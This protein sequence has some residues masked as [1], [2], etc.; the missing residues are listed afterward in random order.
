MRRNADILWSQ[1]G[2]CGTGRCAVPVLRSVKCVL[3]VNIFE[4]E[5]P[6]IVIRK[7]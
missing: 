6:Q 4:V 3:N 1:L 5:K 7:K 2:F